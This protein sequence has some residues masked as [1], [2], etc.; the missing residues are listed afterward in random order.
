[1]MDVAIVISAN[2]AVNPAARSEIIPDLGHA[3]H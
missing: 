2:D 3:D 1:M